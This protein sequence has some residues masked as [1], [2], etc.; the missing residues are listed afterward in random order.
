MN[1]K[2]L[3]LYNNYY[4]LVGCQGV[5]HLGG[6]ILGSPWQLPPRFRL[7]FL[8][9]EKFPCI[10]KNTS[11]ILLSHLRKTKVEI[12]VVIFFHGT[13]HN[14]FKLDTRCT[15]SCIGTSRKKL[16]KPPWEGFSKNHC[17]EYFIGYSLVKRSPPSIVPVQWT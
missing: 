13:F 8:F 7:R 6:L 12:F 9:T 14:I 15:Y 4:Y 10:V 11:L 3:K 17:R 5:V 2:K 16:P 1:W